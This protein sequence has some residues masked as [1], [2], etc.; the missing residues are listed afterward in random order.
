VL[1]FGLL[2]WMPSGAQEKST[3]PEI[4]TKL[5][6]H[7]D[8]VYCV[9]YSPDGKYLVT[10]S[11]DHTLKLWDVAAAKEVKTYAGKDGHQKMVLSVAFS[12]DGQ[13]IAS[14]GADNTLK[15]WDVP[16]G[17]PIRSFKAADAT[18]AVALTAD[19]TKLAVGGKD[20]V[21]KVLNAAD[22]KELLKLDG[23]HQGAVTGVAFSANGQVLVSTS[24]DRTARFW[25]ATNGQL[26]ATVGAHAGAANAVA[27]NP[28][29]VA[30]TVGDDGM[31]RF[32]QLNPIAAKAISG[33]TATIRA[34]AVSADGNVLITGGDDKTV[35]HFS[36]PAGKEIRPLTG[37]LAPVTSVTLNPANSVIAAASQD[38]QVYFWNAADGKPAG[39]LTAHAGPVTDVQFHPQGTQVATAGADG[40][41]RLWAYPP[42]PAR[43]A[44]HPDGVLVAVA[45]PDGKKLYT[46]SADKVLRIWDA[47][48]PAVERQFTGH[49]GAITALAVSANGQLLVSGGADATLRF[50]NQATAKEADVVTAHAAPITSLALNPAATQVVSTSEDG[51]IKL[52]QLPFVAPKAFVHADQVTGL[53]LTADGTKLV[54]G[55]G[56]KLVRLWNLATGAKEREYPGGPTLPITSVAVSGNGATVAAAALDKTVTLWNAADGKVLHKIAVPAAAQVVVFSPDGQSVAAGLADGTVKLLAVADAKETKSLAAHKAA[57]SGLAFT[58]KGDVLFSAGGDK[59]VQ[60]WALPDGTPQARFELESPITAL[61]LSRDGAL[62]AAAGAKSVKVWGLPNAKVVASWTSPAEVGGIALSPD[63]ARVALAGAD[64]LARV[65][66]IDGRL[67]ES[68]PHDGPVQAIAFIDPKRLVTGSTDKTARLWN[69]ALLWHKA[70]AGPVRRAVF[71][72]KGDQVLSAGDDKTIRV[73]NVPDGK[74]VKVLPA[75]EGAVTQL[76]LSADGTRLASAGADKA[77][78]VWA[79]ADGKVIATL[80]IAGPATALVLSPNGQRVAVAPAEGKECPV[81]VLDAA[82]GGEIQAL[83]D[84]TAPVLSLAFQADNRTLVTGSL[85][86][87]AR[88]LDVTAL[89]AFA[90]HPPGPVHIQY[91]NTGTQLLT[92]GADKTV[93]LWDL[94]KAAVIKTFGPVADPVRAIAFSKDYTQVA[95]A[96]GKVVKVWNVADGKEVATLP[97]P[98]DV[99]SLSFN[100]D[101]TR[102]ATGAADRQTRLWELATGRELQFFPQTDPV[103]A[104]AVTAGGAVVSAAG[105]VVQIET[106]AVARVIPAGQGSL[107]AVTVAPANT[108]VLTAGADNA[109]K[110]WNV[111]S[112][113]AERTFGGAG[114]PVKAVAVA[115]NNQLVAAA[116]ADKTVRVYQL[117]DGKELGSVQADGEVRALAFTPNSLTMV[118]AIADKSMVAWG[119]PFAP[120]QPPSPDFLK[121]LQ[122]FATPEPVQ[123]LVIANDNATV[124]TAGLDKAVH[125]WKL[126]SPVPTRNFPHPNLIDAVAFQPNGTLLASGGHD[127]KVRL[128]D[129]VK[130][131]Q[132]KEITAH[133]D[134]NVGNTIYTIAFS[135]DGKQLLTSSLD[136]S[137]KLWDVASGNLVREFK[138]HK[139][140]EFEKGHQDPVYS[141]TLSPDGKLLASGSGSIERVI[142]IWNVADGSVVR[143]LANPQ[144]KAPPSQPPVSHPGDILQ[145]RFTKG[146]KLISLGDAPKNTG[147]LAVWDPQAGTMLFGETLPMGTFYSMALSPDEG[148]LAVAAGNRGKANPEFNSVYL[149]RLPPV[150]K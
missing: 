108:H 30:Y 150:A 68:F 56:D 96:A 133:V 79:L 94:A 124:F 125:A 140:K 72:P 62:L 23:Q 43:T 127:G 90:A 51:T 4:I 92:G 12:P 11:L 37:P 110:L 122:T 145:L 67:V 34:L 117:A 98:A 2:V 74:E 58:P 35:R 47:T 61:A 22:F 147:F 149:L 83:A 49:T 106:P 103:E 123:D 71:S 38:R 141:A 138:A 53:A 10:G 52:W 101:K 132:A 146:G 111:S 121:P 50:W 7:T 84:H 41:V 95:V 44:P 81:R 105:K 89:A 75:P 5:K 20:G 80:P 142:K 36:P 86:K 107:H 15:V 87:S 66:E 6:G 120:G 33:N 116:G 54:T 48:K 129:L 104:V 29:G 65:Y 77:V 109:V 134:K 17:T 97:H 143:D 60:G 99:L 135:A 8:G 136:H 114:A 69:S 39:Q 25:N 3:G 1:V 144:I 27:I 88:L 73:W 85:D 102:V 100:Q 115:K 118:A 128:F 32:W 63:K 78:K 19:G 59:V 9:A 55:S 70:S 113:A 24:T 112:G 21:V 42:T 82:T 119:T 126:A 93:K 91:L 31:L 45:S 148:T 40:L 130:N 76:S 139:V 64:K 13:M 137:L 57:V 131:A 16:I 26:L 46:G 18:T 14:G 28:G